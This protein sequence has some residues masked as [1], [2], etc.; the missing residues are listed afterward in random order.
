MSVLSAGPDGRVV[1]AFVGPAK[2]KKGVEMA[3]R[4]DKRV[5]DISFVESAALG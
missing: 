4:D 1:L 3:L 2:L 5:T